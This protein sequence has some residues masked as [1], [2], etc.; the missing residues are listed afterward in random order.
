[1]EIITDRSNGRCNGQYW[2]TDGGAM[3]NRGLLSLLY[4]LREA[5]KKINKN[6][7]PKLHII[8]ADASFESIDYIQ[9]KRGIGGKLDS[10][11]H[12]ASEIS[13]ELFEDINRYICDLKGENYDKSKSS[14]LKMYY[15]EM[16]KIFRTRGGLGTHWKMPQNIVFSDPKEFDQKD[17]KT[18][19][20]KK[21]EVLNLIANLHG[22]GDC[23]KRLEKSFNKNIV[24]WICNDD[25]HQEVW[26]KI[27]NNLK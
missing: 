19:D 25:K 12:L 3:D 2:I 10:S 11:V 14:F 24:S 8:V 15:L 26:S 4:S 21:H 13:N 17:A 23:K 22:K 7:L 27:T 20:L 16:P 18:E 1:L 9:E 6:E 5:V